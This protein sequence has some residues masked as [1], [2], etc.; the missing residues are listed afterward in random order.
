[1]GIS[2][3]RGTVPEPLRR[4]IPEVPKTETRRQHPNLE[5][6]EICPV[7]VHPFFLFCTLCLGSHGLGKLPEKRKSPKVVRGGCKRSFGPREQKSPKSLLHHP[8]PLLHRREMG[9]HRCRRRFARWVQKTC[10]TLSKP[11]LGSF[12][13][14]AV[15]QLRGFPTL[16]WP[17]LFLPFSGHLLAL[18]SPSKSALFCRAKG[19]VQ[20]SER[21]NFRTDLST[22]F[23][24]EI[25]S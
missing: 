22:K 8:N 6:L 18:F 15:S 1:M 16:C 12:S 24:K 4:R 11:L 19:T 14:R 2:P 20:S 21:V 7:C 3:V 10:C 5:S 9:L 23:G 25:P 17:P 13:F